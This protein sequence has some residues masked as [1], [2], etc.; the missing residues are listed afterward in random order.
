MNK[1][2]LIKLGGAA[3]ENSDWVTS[4]CKELVRIRSMG[5]SVVVVHGGGPAINQELKRRGIQ[6]QFID[7]QRVTTPDMMEVIEMVLCGSVNRKIVRILNGM[8]M[9]AIGFSGIDG[10]TLLCKQAD[11]RL[12]QVGTIEQ[13]DPKTILSIL[14]RD[15]KSEKGIIPIIAPIGIGKNGESYNINADW[16]A[17]WIAQALKIKTLIFLTDQDG[18]LDTNRKPISNVD[19][20]GL[21]KLIKTETV[22]GGMLTKTR[23]VLHSLKNNTKE[24][25]I[26]N[27]HRPFPWKGQGTF[28]R[29]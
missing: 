24:V 3:L 28:C 15:K 22:T 11:P 10:K 4:I 14:E 19:L 27:S 6:W 8:G 20:N 17:T 9:P 25:Y 29:P 21:Q 18:I 23:A 2:I 16:A 7:G 12:G 13:V 5:I 1:R 26:L